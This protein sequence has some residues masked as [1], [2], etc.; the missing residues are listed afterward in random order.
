MKKYWNIQEGVYIC[1]VYHNAPSTV[2]LRAGELYEISVFYTAE[3]SGEEFDVSNG[4]QKL[5]KRRR[6]I[7][8]TILSGKTDGKRVTVCGAKK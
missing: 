5:E 1:R 4:L 6:R 7:S 8:E 2:N 3:I